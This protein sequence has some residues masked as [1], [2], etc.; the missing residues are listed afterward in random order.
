MAYLNVTYRGES[1]KM[2][3]FVRWDKYIFSVIQQRTPLFI[4]LWKNVKYLILGDSP[5]HFGTN[6]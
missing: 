6:E 1:P 3:R 4:V 2:G 5:L